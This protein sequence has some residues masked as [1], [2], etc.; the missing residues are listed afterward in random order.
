MQKTI[1][2]AKDATVNLTEFTA[3]PLGHATN[4]DGAIAHCGDK[5]I[6]MY[7]HTPDSA[8]PG[9]PYFKKS[10]EVGF[11]TPGG[12]KLGADSGPRLAKFQ[13]P[14]A[15]FANNNKLNL[16]QVPG[17]ADDAKKAA[18]RKANASLF[19]GTILS[20]VAIDFGGSPEGK[21]TEKLS[22]DEIKAAAKAA[23]IKG[24]DMDGMIEFASNPANVTREVTIP[25][26]APEKITLAELAKK[27]PGGNWE[28]GPADLSVIQ[29]T[30]NSMIRD[31]VRL[32]A[33]EEPT[34]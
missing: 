24:N 5:P 19:L 3:G 29:V 20:A 28:A 25:A 10:G 7:G 14:L 8:S 27:A 31:A 23:G 30:L 13:V 34:A 17:D 11:Y 26:V 12:K 1:A 32:V 15:V 16:A 4:K 33:V 18:V 9:Q 2:I 22:K 21:T 6:L